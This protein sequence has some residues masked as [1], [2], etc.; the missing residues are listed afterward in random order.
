[1]SGFAGL[2][3]LLRL[4]LRRDRI[5]IPVSVLALVVLAVESAQATIEL[6]PTD[7]SK[8]EAIQTL[9]S[10]TIVAMYGPVA[11]TTDLD[12]FAVF[13]TLLLG[14][15]ALAIVAFAIVRR[16]TRTEEEAGRTELLG[17]GVVGRRA[18]L[19]AAVLLAAGTTVLTGVLAAVGL[20]AIGLGAA[21]SWAF[22]VAWICIGLSFT[23]IT[24]LAA[25][26]TT[27]TRGCAAWT[28]GALGVA[29]VLR[30]IGD[31]ATGPA[32][33]LTWLSPLGWAEQIGVFG[34][35][36]FAVALLPIAFSIAM[37]AA[38]YVILD[39]RD[40]GAGILPERPGPASADPGLRS[41]LALAWRLQRGA[42]LGWAVGFAA[43]GLVL[44]GLATSVNDMLSSPQM[45]DLLKKLAVGG[46]TLTDVYLS[47]E[48]QFM[49][50][51]AAAYGISAALRLRSEE[52]DLH[53]EQLLA[54]SVT[55]RSLLASHSMVALLGSAALML[56]VGFTAA[57]S[58]GA[59][60]Y[61][62]GAALSHLMP[63]ALATIP[64]VWVCV[65]L[66]LAIFGSMPKVVYLAWGLLA[67]FVVVG[68]FGSVLSLPQPVIGLSPFDHGQ[69]APGGTFGV[70]PLLALLA[71]AA[72]L[73]ALASAGFRRR[74]LA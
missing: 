19:T 28:M 41:P 66:A 26:L 25:Q 7:A 68:E 63:S 23:G 8:L 32:S 52:V 72:G 43:L 64:P 71:V 13:K 5:L 4:G 12:S 45:A 3:T 11:N 74:D 18:P 24:A 46:S 49:A 14:G 33:A 20:T 57:L 47:T 51:G 48:L 2:G 16:H 40:L 15:I 62:V 69:V 60:G 67:A 39:R 54:T 21:G 30:A 31:T 61:G 50:I 70:G 29:Y 9:L 17:A 36:R 37:I 56:L 58:Y 59:T 42:L 1:M 10:P 6:Y 44:G 55:R 35:N 65:G 22:G 34:A 73:Y 38:A 27:T 53:T